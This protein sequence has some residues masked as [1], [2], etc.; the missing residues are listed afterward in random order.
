MW[1]AM[2]V[3]AVATALL[4]EIKVNPFGTVFRFGL[5]P[6]AMAF[7]LL[8]LPRLPP[9]G[10]GLATAAT[11]LLLRSAAT[12]F[13]LAGQSAASPGWRE[14]LE[15]HGPGAAYYAAMGALFQ[16]LRLRRHAEAP[17]VLT[18]LLAL[19]DVAANSIEMLLRQMWGLAA[20][21]MPA[22][23]VTGVLRSTLVAGAY[24]MAYHRVAEA[25]WLQERA[26]RERLLM[27]LTGL[28][29][30]VFFLGKSA[31]NIEEVMAKSYRLHR[32]LATQP[33]RAELA[34][35]IAREVHEVKKDYRRILSGLERLLRRQDLPAEMR[36]SEVV[37]L[38][39][40][41][42]ER[43]AAALGKQ[44]EFEAGVE[45]DF[46]TPD[47]GHWVSILNNL[48]ANAVE[49]CG[50]TGRVRVEARVED[51][52]AVVSV[53]DDGCGIPDEDWEVI[54]RPGYSTKVDPETGN[55]STGLGLS[56]VRQ[57][58][59]ALGGEIAVDR[60]GPGGTTFRIELPAARP[61]PGAARAAAVARGVDLAPPG[62]VTAGLP[63]VGAETVA[64]GNP[65]R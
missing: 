47:S 15:W 38:V 33:G 25:R 41:A 63:G 20:V 49:A 36:F 6:P 14:L 60:S 5:G 28:R 3:V 1:R 24:F 32:E 46:A 10:T 39:L 52:V 59:G 56:H 35:E 61:V 4:A 18:A 8:L 48:V 19:T 51:G 21:L 50:P 55:F 42:G 7:A 37:G 13:G 40:A 22:A 2:A 64:G 30:E 29:S 11:V 17:V 12:A 27:L 31:A 44:V 62:A 58:V 57:L 26:E 43:H 34:L 9:A 65:V 53:A 16:G 45:H 54:F 23:L